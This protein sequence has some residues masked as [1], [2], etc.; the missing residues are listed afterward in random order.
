[1]AQ[2]TLTDYPSPPLIDNLRLN[3]LRNLSDPLPAGVAVE[4][5][6]WGELESDFAASGKHRYTRILAADTL[7]MSFQHTNLVASMAHFLERTQAARVLIVA[8][9]HTGREPVEEFF[10]IASSAGL[11]VKE[12]W[13]MN[14]D[15]D[16]REWMER[17]EML[18]EAKAWFVVA[19]LGWSA[20][21][22]S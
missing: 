11:E 19:E 21:M 5:H 16:R 3:A 1:L 20:K 7:W 4:P 2:V 13:E 14:W 9:F 17:P 6:L 12:I 18:L 10:V 8:K 15:G 22:L